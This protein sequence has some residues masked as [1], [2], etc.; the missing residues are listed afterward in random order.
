M[1][2]FVYL[3][4]HFGIGCSKRL[5][6]AQIVLREAS[7]KATSTSSEVSAIPL[8]SSWKSTVYIILY[9]QTVLKNVLLRIL[10]KELDL[11]SVSPPPT[12][13]GASLTSSGFYFKQNRSS[14]TLKKLRLL[15]NS[16]YK[17]WY[18]VWVHTTGSR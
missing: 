5:F 11:S 15:R 13:F 17:C 16:I 3:S 8:I 2:I 10:L 9:K 12:G 1:K 14:K 4:E 7:V 18:L 6:S